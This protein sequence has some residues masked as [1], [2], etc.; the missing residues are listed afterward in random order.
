MLIKIIKLVSVHLGYWRT[1]TYLLTIIVRNS[2]ATRTSSCEEA[3]A[4]H[5]RT[6]LD[7]ARNL[8][9]VRMRAHVYHWRDVAGIV[10]LLPCKDVR[11]Q[12]GGFP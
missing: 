12:A 9:T 4:A 6:H 3:A 11:N 1:P 10:G 2:S 7:N 8:L 5:N